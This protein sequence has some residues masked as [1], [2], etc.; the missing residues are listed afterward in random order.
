MKRWIIGLAAA[1]CVV[2]ACS[3][4]SD[5]AILPYGVH[6]DVELSTVTD[7]W[8]WTEIY[9]ADYA[10]DDVS[11]SDMFSDAGEYI[12]LA[13]RNKSLSTIDVLAAVRTSDFFTTN[14]AGETTGVIPT[15]LHETRSLNGAE[16]YL[17]EWSLGFAGQDDTIFQNDADMNGIDERDRLSWHTR[18]IDNVWTQK[19]WVGGWRSGNNV[20]LNEATHW[21]KIVFTADFSPDIPEPS[22]LLIWSLL[23]VLGIG[24]SWYRKRR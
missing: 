21:E 4:H 16:W 2:F 13:G 14:S 12:M 18:G 19:S 8:G 1:V 5:A 17:N 9:R 10:A 15:G 11:L 22:T 6:N 7:T 24:V 20:W 3:A 23:G